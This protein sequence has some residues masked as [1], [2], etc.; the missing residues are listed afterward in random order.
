MLTVLLV[1]VLSVL[2]SGGAYAWLLLRTG[3]GPEQEA[4][5][6][7][8]YRVGPSCVYYR[9]GDGAGETVIAV[10]GFLESPAYFTELYREDSAALV[11][12]GN[13]DYH[14]ALRPRQVTEP[15]WA[16]SPEAGV[17]TIE[18]DAEVLIQVME[19][20]V[21]TPAVLL[22]GHSRGGAVVLEAAARRPDL[23]GSARAILEAPVLPQARQ[24]RPVPAVVIGALPLLLPLWRRRPINR[25]NRRVWGSLDDARKRRV[26][27]ALPWNVR[28]ALTVRRNLLNIADWVESRQANVFQGLGSASILVPGRDRVLDPRSMQASAAEGGPHVEVVRLSEVSHFVTLDAPDAVRRVRE[29]GKP[30]DDAEA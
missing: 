6:G 21:T 23:F 2:V 9:R 10:H 15:P 14:P 16:R 29:G 25:F 30:H 13:G 22:H 12:L 26:I 27:S 4:F 24:P 17:G 8:L 11:L 7:E 18:H 19:H 1:V 28:R 20:L 3:P 5:D